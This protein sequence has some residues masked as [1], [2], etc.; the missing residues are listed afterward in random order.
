MTT[1]SL[2]KTHIRCSMKTK[3]EVRNLLLQHKK[4]GAIKLL[5]NE[6]V[7]WNNGVRI[8][9]PGLR[10]AKHAVEHLLGELSHDEA[11]AVITAL[12]RVKRVVIDTGDGEAELDLDGLQLRLLDGLCAVPIDIMADGLRLM[13]LLRAFDRGEL[14][15]NFGVNNGKTETE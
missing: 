5:R 6:S 10:E 7:A 14:D 4:I 13:E 2:S 1:S 11:C 15:A 3:A 12:P 9:R 8:E